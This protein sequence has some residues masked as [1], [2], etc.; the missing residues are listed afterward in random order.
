MPLFTLT[1]M[2]VVDLM[3][4]GRYTQ[5]AWGKEQRVL[6]LNML[7][8]CFTKLAER[9]LLGKG[10]DEVRTDYRKF[11]IGS[12]IVFYRQTENKTIEVVRILHCNMDAEI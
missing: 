12:H 5:Q 9:L 11:N 8:A 3:E 1:K 2:A 7:D 4:I 10:C 6:Y